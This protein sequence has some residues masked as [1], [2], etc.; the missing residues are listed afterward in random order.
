MD[1]REG[2]KGHNGGLGN[3]RV[4]RDHKG[5]WIP[6]WGLGNTRGPRYYKL[7][8]GPQWS[9]R[10]MLG[11]L[12]TTKVTGGPNGGCGSELGQEITMDTEDPDAARA[13]QFSPH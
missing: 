2:A 1:H 12:V 11:G 4:T 6:R 10:G 3:R 7:A 9:P 13:P 5:A 8:R